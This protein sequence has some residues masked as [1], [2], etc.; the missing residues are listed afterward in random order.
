MKL[1]IGGVIRQLR[2]ARNITQEE[3]AECLGV[4]TQSVSRWENQLCYPD[5]ELIPVLAD[6]FSVSIDTLMG[7]DDTHEKRRVA[8]WTR[9]YEAALSTGRIGE[10]IRSAREG[11][12]EYPN[13][14][15]LLEQLMDA[16]FLSTDN[17]GG[18]PDWQENQQRYDSEI[19]ALG[20]RII[21]YCPDKDIRWRAIT[22]LA[23]HH[24]EMGRLALGRSVYQKLPTMAWCREAHQW[25]SLTEEEKLP[26]VQRYIAESH[27]QLQ[28]ALG[29]LGQK[30]LLDDDAALDV[31]DRRAALDRL[32]ALDT[33]QTYYAIEA[34]ME[35]ARI[36][37]RLHRPDR[38]Y[39]ELRAAALAA[40]DFDL[41]PESRTTDNVFFGALTLRRSNFRT[42]D[43]RPLLQI[44]REDWLMEPDFDPYREQTAFREIL[45]LCH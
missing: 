33:Q 7:R 34:H 40:R 3:L 42:T 17:S 37:A 12:A 19:V 8:A 9:A 44:L 45:A 41:R 28:M 5:M 26:F 21:R 13:N 16:L 11:A 30:R 25:W 2:K 27:H 35:P 15:A 36:C 18:I 22:R 43:P 20:E 14:Y 23:F 1:N 29:L 10:C 38:M 6:Y 39:A 31:L 24:C 4:T 32:L